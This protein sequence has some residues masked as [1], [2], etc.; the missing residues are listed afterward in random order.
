MPKSHFGVYSHFQ[1]LTR[2]TAAMIDKQRDRPL[3]MNVERFPAALNGAPVETAAVVMGLIG[4]FMPEGH[5]AFRFDPAACSETLRSQLP[6]NAPSKAELT[7]AL[8]G[9]LQPYL[10]RFFTELP[11]GR[12]ALSPDIFSSI[13]GNPGTVS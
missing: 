1:N 11:D 10:L 12:W 8:L 6:D 7:P 13:D 5:G 3:F 9:R 4:A 2:T